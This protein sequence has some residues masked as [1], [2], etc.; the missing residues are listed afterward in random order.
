VGALASR[1]GFGALRWMHSKPKGEPFG[2]FTLKETWWEDH[3][4]LE[5]WRVASSV[6]VTIPYSI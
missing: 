4:V 5:T 2:C 1:E 3:R 6:L